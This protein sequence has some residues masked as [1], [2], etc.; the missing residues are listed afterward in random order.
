MRLSDKD[1]QY[2]F[3]LE[4]G[5]DG[6][7]AFDSLTE[8][9]R[10][11]CLILND[12]LLKQNNTLFQIDSLIITEEWVY[13]FEVKNY[14]GDYLYDSERFY[15]T[16]NSE[17]TNP[18]NQLIR[19]ESLLRRLFQNIGSNLPIHA[20]VVFINPEFTLYQAPLNFPFIFPT[21][22]SKQLTKLSTTPSKLSAQHKMLADKLVSMHI[23][24]PPFN[25]LPNYDYSK[26]QKGITC[27]KCA[28]FSVFIE[29]RKC[30]CKKCRYEEP[31]SAAILRNV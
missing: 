27:A 14:E 25:Q 1:Q 13:L 24:D 4:K 22:I 9:L 21:Q 8:T 28:S 10:C 11:E 2:Y 15:K 3:Y 20:S 29:G 30:V 17:I 12:L 16:P 31:S 26:L 18:F 23:T 5:F 7:K 6:E 19:C